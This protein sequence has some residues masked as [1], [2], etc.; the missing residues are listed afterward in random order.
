MKCLH[1]EWYF[2]M[3]CCRYRFLD[4]LSSLSWMSWSS[5]CSVYNVS[6]PTI[7]DAMFSDTTK[8]KVSFLDFLSSFFQHNC[9]FPDLGALI[10][11]SFSLLPLTLCHSS[12][13][14]CTTYSKPLRQIGTYSEFNLIFIEAAQSII[15]FDFIS[16]GCFE[17]EAVRLHLLQDQGYGLGRGKQDRDDTK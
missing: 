9:I 15:N 16:S 12:P 14:S 13:D 4:T 3:S 7:W 10:K 1:S 17:E 8:L 5:L 11:T 2:S 6:W